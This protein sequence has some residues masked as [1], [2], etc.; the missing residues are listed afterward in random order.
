MSAEHGKLLVART[1]HPTPGCPL[2]VFTG[3]GFAGMKVVVQRSPT[4][5]HALI[6]AR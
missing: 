4:Y 6:D 1:V 3:T 5:N 2:P